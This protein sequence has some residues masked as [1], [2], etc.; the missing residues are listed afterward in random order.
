[1]VGDSPS[2]GAFSVRAWVRVPDVFVGHGCNK[3]LLD[4]FSRRS[5]ENSTGLA[6]HGE[7]M[8]RFGG[9]SLCICTGGHQG[10]A[11]KVP[12]DQTD[13]VRADIPGNKRYDWPVSVLNAIL[14]TNV[15]TFKV[16]NATPSPSLLEHRC[17]QSLNLPPLRR[18]PP[19]RLPQPLPLLNILDLDSLL[20][21]LNAQTALLVHG[22]G[23]AGLETRAL[24]DEGRGEAGI[25]SL[26]GEVV[27]WLVY[28][29]V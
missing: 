16:Q 5:D 27:E 10:A 12:R 21:S 22:D 25:A 7:A 8:L 23:L 18:R 11:I 6:F 19:R 2:A 3:C 1:M 13:T 17:P 9:R 26:E 14:N 15:S 20:R 29:L 4:A 24:G 28:A